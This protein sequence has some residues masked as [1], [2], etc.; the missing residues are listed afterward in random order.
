MRNS[1]NKL[2]TSKRVGML[3]A[4][5]FIM[6]LSGITIYSRSFAERQKT[7]VHVT[8][9]Q[10]ASA[11]WDYETTSTI[12]PATPE[13]AELGAE[14][15]VTFTIP[16]EVFGGFTEQLPSVR[17]TA[18]TDFLLFPE[19]LPSILWRYRH[20][21]G[22]W[23]L[24]FSYTSPNRE[25]RNQ[26]IMAG[27]PVTINVQPID[28]HAHFTN[29]L[30]Q[31]AIREDIFTGE[32]FIL[33]LERRSSAWGREYVTVRHSITLAPGIPAVGNLAN[34]MLMPTENPIIYWSERPLMPF[35]GEVVRIFD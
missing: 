14:W 31:S 28:F 2:I 30:P 11:T 34:L 15:T 18:T 7:L 6:G 13:F 33:S 27:E 1:E 25:M 4:L 24:T 12:E 17:A 26:L 19:I 8:F 21:N 10:S 5:V 29:L 20:D 35:G 16:F 32:L 3:L 23:T 22:D 9:P